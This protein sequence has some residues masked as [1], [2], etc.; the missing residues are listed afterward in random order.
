MVKYPVAEPEFRTTSSARDF[1]AVLFKHKVKIVTI[2][3]AVVLTS[4]VGSFVMTP[5]YEAKTSLLMKIGREHLNRSDLGDNSPVNYNLR[6]EEIINSEIEILTNRNLIEKVVTTMGVPALYPDLARSK[7]P[8][9]MSP[10][11]LAVRRFGENLKVSTVKKSNVVEVTFRHRDPQVAAKTLNTLVE[12]FKEKHLQVFSDSRSSFYESQLGDYEKKLKD[13]AEKLEKFKQKNGVYSLE[14]QRSLL[15]RQR[16]DLDSALKASQNHVD[17]LQ[18]RLATV[19]AQ[20]KSLA[21]S[22]QHYTTTER[23]R[24]VTETKSRLLALQLNEQE[25]LRK[26]RDDSR[27]VTSNRDEIKMVQQFLKEQE[28]DNRKKSKTN[29]PIYQGVEA[30]MMKTEADLNS[31]RAKAA[32]L[33]R[34]LAQVDGEVRSLDLR[35]KDMQTLKREMTANEKN[36]Q[37]YREKA[38]EARIADDMNKHKLANVSVIESAAPP[39]QPV[40]PKKKVN[41]ALGVVIGIIA[42]MALAFLSETLSQTVSTPGTAEKRLGLPVLAVIPYKE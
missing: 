37:V 28:E 10:Q 31:Q 18:R 33:R 9:G 42:A 7:P 36:Q 40:S 1:F 16:T 29:S 23:D 5:T 22:N 21:D 14:E 20:F 6:Q 41:V 19:R 3:L 13:T 2:F 27:L 4:L 34:Q 24:V 39:L 12:L 17:E 26:Y 11:D 15:L 38:E 30:E 8:Q 35:E 25:L 32:T